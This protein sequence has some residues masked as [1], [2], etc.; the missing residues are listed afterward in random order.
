MLRI[1][2]MKQLQ[3]KGNDSVTNMNTIPKV[4]RI[5]TKP[6]NIN[7]ISI[8]LSTKL[9]QIF[10]ANAGLIFGLFFAINF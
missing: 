1:L 6:D 9:Q 7:T 4:I 2:L 8:S 5:A 3:K 10:L